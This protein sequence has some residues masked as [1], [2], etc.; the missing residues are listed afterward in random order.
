MVE[1]LTEDEQLEALKKWWKENGTAIIVGII[2]GVSAIVGFWK[3][4][5]HVENQALAAS[6]EYDNFSQAII[7][8]KADSIEKSYIVLKTEYADT[9]YAALAALLFASY[10]YEKNNPEKTLELLRWAQEQPGH[11]AIFHIAQIRLARL[12]VSLDKY[13]EAFSLVDKI[14][15]PAFDAQYSEIKGDIYNKRGEQMLARSSYQLALASSKLNGKQREF[16][17]MKLDD[18]GDTKTEIKSK[19]KN[20]DSNELKSQAVKDMNK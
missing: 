8:N 6:Q 15:E 9:S 18:L 12:L 3:W 14:N 5:Q 17:Q 7:D 10:E 11:D 4:N 1:Q 19:T 13:D 2:I 20:G 16:V